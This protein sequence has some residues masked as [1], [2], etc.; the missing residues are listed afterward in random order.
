MA[1]IAVKHIMS[2]NLVS[3]APDDT[4]YFAYKLLK[5]HKVRQLPVCVEGRLVGIITDRDI[6]QVIGL[7][8]DS[9]SY[10]IPNVEFDK[11]VSDYM[12]KNPITIKPETPIETAV[13]IIN[14]KKYGSV[15]VCSDN[16]LIVGIVT[17]T[18]ISCLLLKLLKK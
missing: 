9:N 12:T 17:I 2:T 8:T 14:T 1:D 13:Q 5:R 7:E 6:R 15:P 10:A 4:V 3:V 11:K 16:D 18:D